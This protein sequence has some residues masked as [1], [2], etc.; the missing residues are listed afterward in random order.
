M[1][2]PDKLI[3]AGVPYTVSEVA[4]LKSDDGNALYYG[5]VQ[6]VFLTIEIEKNLHNVVKL[7][8][9]LHEALHALFHQT[10]HAD[11]DSEERVVTMLGCQLPRLFH[12]NPE[13][14]DIL[15]TS[16]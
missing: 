7:Q 1:K 13:L 10:G 9:L 12:D 4:D 11:D 2:L 16:E 5:C 15:G 14:L 3:I 6:H 8:T